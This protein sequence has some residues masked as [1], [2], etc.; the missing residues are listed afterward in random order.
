MKTFL[1]SLS[2]LNPF[3]FQRTPPTVSKLTQKAG[4]KLNQNKAMLNVNL[5]N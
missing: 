4:F 2:Y 3:F 5:H 1:Y